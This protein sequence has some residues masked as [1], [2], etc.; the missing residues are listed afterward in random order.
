MNPAVTF[1]MAIWRGFPW[2]KVPV[3]WLAQF[4]GAFTGGA[5][6]FANYRKAFTA[7]SGEGVF[8]VT[9][10]NATANVLANYPATFM[11][12]VGSFFSAVLG[13]CILLL[14]VLGQS[15]ENNMHAAKNSPLVVAFTILS[16]G[17]SLTWETGYSSE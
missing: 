3:Y 11:T 17:L 12:P 1:C 7:Y 14:V 2:K 16:I 6:V 8:I 4:L 15:D 10:P 5:I 9:G 13:T